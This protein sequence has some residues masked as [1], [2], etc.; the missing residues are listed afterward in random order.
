MKIIVV[1]G[2]YAGMACLTELRRRMPDAQLHLYDPRASHLKLT[3]LHET[4]RHPL[5]RYAIDFSSLAQRFRFRHHRQRVAVDDGVLRADDDALDYDFAVLATGAKPVASPI[6]TNVYDRDALIATAA[7]DR[8][9][10]LRSRPDRP[11]SISVVGGGPSG[12]QFLFEMASMPR[13]AGPRPGLRLIDG[14]PR[15]LA[16][17]PGAVGEYVVNKMRDAGIEYLPDTRYI[18]ASAD[19]IQVADEEGERELPSGLTLVFAGLE[20]APRGFEA[21]AAGRIEGLRDAYGAGDCARYDTR[22]DDSMTAQ[23]AVRQGKH[24]ARNID[25]AARGV[26]PLE[27]YFRE[28]GYVVSLGEADAAGWMLLKDRVVTGLAAFAVKEFVEAQYDLFV[29]GIDTYLI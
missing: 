13:G 5:R 4:V 9:A 29:A 26:E 7:G 15:P 1:G 2:G 21:D 11:Q 8:I 22:G 27:Y 12:V 23:V 6:A 20:P 3:H 24:I 16:A 14:G 10:E 17:Q 25:R 28:L 18:G 19:S